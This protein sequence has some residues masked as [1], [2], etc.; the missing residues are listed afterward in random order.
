M[1]DQPS[2]PIDSEAQFYAVLE[3]ALDSDGL[4][5]PDDLVDLRDGSQAVVREDY[6]A[7]VL[8]MDNEVA[9]TIIETCEHLF[10]HECE[11]GALTAKMLTFMVGALI[12]QAR[13]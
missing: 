9:D 11:R 4:V 2:E 7:V 13:E 8:K 3:D 5:T 1:S 6:T 10:S 12:V